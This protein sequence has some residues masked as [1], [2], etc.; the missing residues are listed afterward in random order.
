MMINHILCSLLTEYELKVDHLPDL[1]VKN[2]NLTLY[3]VMEALRTKHYSINRRKSESNNLD[4][5]EA[6][7]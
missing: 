1:I 7:A 5:D 3:Q 2:K 6:P 4:I